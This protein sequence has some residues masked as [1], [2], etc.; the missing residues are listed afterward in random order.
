[1]P[2]SC[3]W[4]GESSSASSVSFFLPSA[5]VVPEAV[6]ELGLP[7]S[8]IRVLPAPPLGRPRE[9]RG[10]VAEVAS[11]AAAAAATSSALRPPLVLRRLRPTLLLRADALLFLQACAFGLQLC[12]CMPR[13][14]A[15]ARS[16]PRVA[17]RA[18]RALWPAQREILGIYRSLGSFSSG[19][20]RRATRRDTRVTRPARCARD[21][22]VHALRA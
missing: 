6:E 22:D 4:S 18:E 2:H 12:S 21:H 15:R 14:G 7:H 1:M 3:L 9:R 17:R 5:R 16:A 10:V 13:S 20:R 19:K 11:E 8:K